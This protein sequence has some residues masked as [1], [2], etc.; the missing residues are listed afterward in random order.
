M[1]LTYV[2]RF[3]KRL[4]IGNSRAVRWIDITVIIGSLIAGAIISSIT[5]KWE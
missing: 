3:L 5:F 2:V 4:W 1:P